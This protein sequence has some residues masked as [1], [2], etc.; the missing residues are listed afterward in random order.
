MCARLLSLLPV[1][2][3]INYL[4]L[5]FIFLNGRPFSLGREG[6]DPFKLLNDRAFLSFQESNSLVSKNICRC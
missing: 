3:P 2:V 4:N 6:F 5:V 1:V